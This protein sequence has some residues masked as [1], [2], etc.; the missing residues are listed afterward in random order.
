MSE[1]YRQLFLAA[2]VLAGLTF[3]GNAMCYVRYRTLGDALKTGA[4]ASI[5]VAASWDLWGWQAVFPKDHSTAVIVTGILWSCTAVVV[6]FAF[7]QTR[8]IAVSYYR[9]RIA[10]L[11][12]VR[13]FLF[14]F[15]LAWVGEAPTAL[16]GV[17]TVVAADSS[18]AIRPKR[19]LLLWSGI[20]LIGLGVAGITKFG[21]GGMISNMSIRVFTIGLLCIAGFAIDS[22]VHAQRMKHIVV[23][24]RDPAECVSCGYNLRGL[25]EKRCPECGTEFGNADVA[26]G[27][28]KA[29]AQ[30][31]AKG[32]SGTI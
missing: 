28:G 29:T 9:A 32:K 14:S 25:T 2:L 1:E 10:K 20:A 19:W 15:G 24:G 30:H 8:V 27:N 26:N 7:I 3:P 23:G 17:R 4:S 16:R 5:A 18:L 21:S 6:L 11:G 31:I 13:R 12:P 22:F